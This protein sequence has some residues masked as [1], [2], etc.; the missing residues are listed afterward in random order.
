LKPDCSSPLQRKSPLL[1]KLDA[2]ETMLQKAEGDPADILQ[3][4]R[5]QKQ[6]Y[7]SKPQLQNLPAVC[8]A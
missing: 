5:W 7:L 6:L 1:N 8:G 2:F 4:A 3:M